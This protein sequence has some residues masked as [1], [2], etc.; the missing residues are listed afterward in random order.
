MGWKK[1][2]K[3]EFLDDVVPMTLGVDL[4]G[5]S[6]Y[7][8]ADVQEILS[9]LT[10]QQHN[11]DET[12]KGGRVG[13][14][15]DFRHLQQVVVDDAR[16]RFQTAYRLVKL[17]QQVSSDELRRRCHVPSPKLSFRQQL[18]RLADEDVEGRGALLSVAV[19]NPAAMH[20][21]LLPVPIDKER[22]V[23]VPLSP[24][25]SGKASADEGSQCRLPKGKRA[26]APRSCPSY[27]QSSTVGRTSSRREPLEIS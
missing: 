3:R 11:D 9:S 1:A 12:M 10:P 21:A 19:Q 7:N 15:V 17:G 23:H 18:E 27:P 4:R 5:H 16:H 24:A 20:K 13:A 22:S 8:L 2:L 26:Q 25:S 6:V 14:M